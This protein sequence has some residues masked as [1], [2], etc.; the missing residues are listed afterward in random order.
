MNVEGSVVARIKKGNEK[1][2]I[3]VSDCEKALKFKDGNI[4][5]DSILVTNDIFKDVKKG[6]HA[7]EHEMKKIFGT[8]D[9]NDVAKIILLEGEILLSTEY[10]N[11]LNGEKKKQIINLIH[12]NAIDPKTNRPHPP[13]RIEA[14]IE[15]AKV[16]INFNK[17]AEQQIQEIVKKISVVLPIKYEIRK[18]EIKIPSNYAGKCFT[19]IKNRAK[20]LSDQWMN[21][22]SLFLVIEIPA[23]MQSDLFDDLNKLTQG[24]IETKIQGV[25]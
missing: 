19:M 20:V 7:S 4:P 24:N 12:R 6:L 21:D 15:E 8:D 3:L 2:E 11:K 16:N 5:L 13:Q 9:N 25:N 14:A 1:F 18:I 23:G 17:P 10:R 22:G